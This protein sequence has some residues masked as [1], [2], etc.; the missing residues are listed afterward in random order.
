MVYG[1]S[2]CPLAYLTECSAIPDESWPLLDG[3]AVLVV[4]ALRHRRHPTHFSVA[5]ALE[6]VQRLRPARA[7]FTHICH[8]LPH[9]ATNASLPDRVEL[10]YDGLSVEFELTQ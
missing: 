7:L 3:V 2:F 5:E 9:V 10:A 8:D 6:V 4:D 1:Y